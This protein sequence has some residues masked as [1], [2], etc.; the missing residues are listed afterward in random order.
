MM[1]VVVVDQLVG[2]ARLVQKAAVRDEQT[3]SQRAKMVERGQRAERGTG[4]AIVVTI[5]ALAASLLLRPAA[6]LLE[7]QMAGSAKKLDAPP[8]EINVLNTIQR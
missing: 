4:E 3:Q 1:L 5:L 2:V 8:R 6:N 7:P